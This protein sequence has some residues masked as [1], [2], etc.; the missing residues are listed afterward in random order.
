MALSLAQSLWASRTPQHDSHALEAICGISVRTTLRLRLALDLLR[1]NP[2]GAI[3][4][5]DLF[6]IVR[7]KGVII[8]K[9]AATFLRALVEAAE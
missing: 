6:S 4:S 3:R 1:S 7:Q 5:S 2:F 8:G 9:M